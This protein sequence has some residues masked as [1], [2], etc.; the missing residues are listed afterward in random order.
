RRRRA[1]PARGGR[2]MPARRRAGGAERT[3]ESGGVVMSGVSVGG[4]RIG[5]MIG[6]EVRGC[7]DYGLTMRDGPD[8]A[9]IASLVGDP[10]R[11]GMLTALMD[12]GALTASE[13]ALEAGVTPPTASSHLARLRE[14]GLVKL[15]AQG[16]H[17]Y[18][19]LADPQVAAM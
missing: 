3:R 12:G 6:I 15:A 9:R 10:A 17:R 18:F 19:S 1:N 5:P 16:R 14:G 8:I 4:I 13:L 11:A 7:F 2:D